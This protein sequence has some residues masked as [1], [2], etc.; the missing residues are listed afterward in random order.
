VDEMYLPF[1]QIP[2]REGALVV[3]G[4]ADPATLARRVKEEVL[5]L[6]PEQPL[7][8]ARPLTEVRADALAP[9]RLTATLLGMFAGLAL[10]ITA[11]GLAGL[12][13]FSVSQRTQE[14]GVRMA[15]GAARSEVMAMVLRHGL[16]LVVIGLVAGA[17]GAL[18]LSRAMS[19]LLYGV[20][21]TDAP[22]F[23]A[24]AAVL[25]SIAALACLIPAR[26]ASTVDPM[27]ALRST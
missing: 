9:A 5:A 20:T 11:A 10:V 19:G 14:I 7:A 25:V 21:P 4:S 12:M 23:A 22:T 27:V 16:R 17:A 26:R 18:A 2:L 8:G 13:A 6:D 1:D 3:R 24:T 15:L